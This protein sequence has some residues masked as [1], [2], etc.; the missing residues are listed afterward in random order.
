MCGARTAH[1]CCCTLTCYI[2]ALFVIEGDTKLVSLVS[3]FARQSESAVLCASLNGTL[4][5]LRGGGVHEPVTARKKERKVTDSTVWLTFEISPVSFC[6]RRIRNT[7][8]F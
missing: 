6:K 1:L 4:G 7:F 5:K 2:K 8:L 3:R